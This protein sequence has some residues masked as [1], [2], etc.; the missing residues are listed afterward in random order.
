M[1]GSGGQHN[2]ASNT[3]LTQNGTTDKIHGHC[4]TMNAITWHSSRMIGFMTALLPFLDGELSTP[5]P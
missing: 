4:G 3:T 1:C 5:T 2:T